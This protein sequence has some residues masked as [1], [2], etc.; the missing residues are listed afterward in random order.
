MCIRDRSSIESE[1]DV[2]IHRNEIYAGVYKF[3]P[4]SS[5]SGFVTGQ[6]YSFRTHIE[7]NQL[8]PS[9]YAP[10]NATPKEN[11]L[12]T[13]ISIPVRYGLEVPTSGDI[14]LKGSEV[15][16]TG[17]LGWI[18]ANSFVD[19]TDSVATVTTN[20]AQVV[21]FRLAGT[22]SPSSLNIVVGSELKFNGFE[23]DPPGNASTDRYRGVNGSRR[24]TSI[25][26]NTTPG[27]TSNVVGAEFTV[28]TQIIVPQDPSNPSE[29]LIVGTCLLYTSDAADE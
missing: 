23:Q 10:S 6:N 12:T 1:G 22:A 4:R 3:N 2:T 25:E 27:F 24:V 17:S 20:G 18:Y 8:D 11:P 16:R 7:V 29:L 13:G 19:I 9:S 14:L 28:T 5:S 21:T 15:G 26:G